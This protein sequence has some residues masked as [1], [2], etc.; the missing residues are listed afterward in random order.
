MKG[1]FIFIGAVFA[2]FV[3]MRWWYIKKGRDVE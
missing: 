3:G 1:V 2:A